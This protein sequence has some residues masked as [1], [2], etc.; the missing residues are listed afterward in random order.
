[1]GPT[2]R[3]QESG[4]GAVSRVAVCPK[5]GKAGSIVYMREVVQIDIWGRKRVEYERLQRPH[6]RACGRGFFRHEIRDHV[7]ERVY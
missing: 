5:C 1:M 3:L 6:C 4:G 7:E 2:E